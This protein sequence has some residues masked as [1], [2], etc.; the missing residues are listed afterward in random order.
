V[1]LDCDQLFSG[2]TD[3][4]TRTPVIRVR[5]SGLTRDTARDIATVEALVHLREL[6]LEQEEVTGPALAVLLRSPYLTRL[7]YLNLARNP[8]GDEGVR[9]LIASNVF[10]Q[11]RYLNLSRVGITRDGVRDLVNAIAL[12]QG[13]A[14]RC[15]LLRDAPT[16]DP[17][18]PYPS[19]PSTVSLPLRQSL[20][21]QLGQPVP[22]GQDLLRELYLTRTALS[23]DLRHWVEWLQETGRDLAWGLKQL[24]LPDAVH[25][26]FAAVCKRRALWRAH[27]NRVIPPAFLVDKSPNALDLAGA[28]TFLTQMTGRSQEVAALTNCLLDLFR[29]YERGEMPPDGRTR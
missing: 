3:L 15:L 5:L 27:R 24:M 22:G 12:G 6:I 20:Q 11:L 2:F 19:L 7:R 28:V 16:Q 1:T 17:R 10:S 8:L 29:R 26:A 4:I 23:A 14:L 21:D 9:A 25:Q 13:N 18:H